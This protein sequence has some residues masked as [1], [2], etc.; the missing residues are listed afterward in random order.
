M[1]DELSCPG[2]NHTEASSSR[3]KTN[4]SDQCDNSSDINDSSGSDISLASFPN[5]EGHIY[6][7]RSTAASPEHESETLNQSSTSN[8]PPPKEEQAE[9]YKARLLWKVHHWSEA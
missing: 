5:P 6:D 7:E 4:W 1:V 8:Q 3:E 2:L 9:V